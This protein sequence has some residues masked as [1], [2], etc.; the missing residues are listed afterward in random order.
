MLPKLTLEQQQDAMRKRQ[1]YFRKYHA[2][3]REERNARKREQRAAD[4]EFYREQDRA[5]KRIPYSLLTEEQKNAR[6]AA[7]QRWRDRHPE[8][9]VEQQKRLQARR[10]ELY[11]N[12][13]TY[14][15]SRKAAS[16]TTLPVKQ[17]EYRTQLKNQVL[18]HYGRVCRCCGETEELFLTLG[19]LNGD[20][21]AH[22]KS[23]GLSGPGGRKGSGSGAALWRDVIRRG[24]PDDFGIECINCNMGAFRNGGV[25]PHVKLTTVA[26]NT[27]A[28]TDQLPCAPEAPIAAPGHVN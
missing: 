1:E 18:D 20:G 23:L 8:I 5:R 4:I 25:C 16:R 14:R 6:R 17:R 13:S 28:S 27:D 22:R 15:E 21:A 7:T 19:H 9:V 24:F 2:E 26:P 12:D 10:R 11:R 3:H